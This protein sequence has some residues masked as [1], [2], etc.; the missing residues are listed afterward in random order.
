MIRPA[1][2]ARGQA[3]SKT[4]R[5]FLCPLLHDSI[6]EGLAIHVLAYCETV[7]KVLARIASG[8]FLQG[9]IGIKKLFTWTADVHVTVAG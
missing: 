7:E 5:I 4:W 3:H 9:E 6:P 2:S 8:A 1:K